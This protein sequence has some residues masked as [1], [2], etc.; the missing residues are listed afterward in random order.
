MYI[1]SHEYFEEWVLRGC[2]AGGFVCDRIAGQL[3]LGF[4][5]VVVLKSY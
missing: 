4:E 2:F 3:I 1:T 5:I